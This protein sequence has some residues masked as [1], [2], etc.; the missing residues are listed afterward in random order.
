MLKPLM[1][2]DKTY[3]CIHK[4]SWPPARAAMP[5]EEVRARSEEKW[6]QLMTW[7][8]LCGL[9]AMSES[10]CPG[11]PLVLLETR[12]GPTRVNVE[13]RVAPVPMSAIGKGNKQRKR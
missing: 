1:V 5:E 11:C 4:E 3:S 2:G 13:D 7:K 6:A 12:D 9:T 8:R 10:K